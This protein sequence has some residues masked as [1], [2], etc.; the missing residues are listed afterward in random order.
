MYYA[1][2]SRYQ[3]VQG[4][5]VSVS[6]NTANNRQNGFSYDAAGNVTGDGLHSYSYDAEGNV[7]TVDGGATAGYTCNALNQRVRTVVGGQGMEF[8]FGANGQRASSW[9]G[10][11]AEV[12]ERLTGAVCRWP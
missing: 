1:P 2:L 3:L 12:E 6:Y 4:G 9:N 7:T 10:A 11:G 8:V 5:N